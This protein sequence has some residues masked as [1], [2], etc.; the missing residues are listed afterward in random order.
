MPRPRTA[1]AGTA[2]VSMD[3]A[4]L[5]IGA[6]SVPIACG[7]C[8]GAKLKNQVSI[9]GGIRV[10]LTSTCFGLAPRSARR[11][12][13]FRMHRANGIGKRIPAFIAPFAPPTR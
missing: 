3:T 5:S 10:E 8:Q 7:D 2:C 4:R 12:P 1:S 13:W 11:V 6:G 9:W